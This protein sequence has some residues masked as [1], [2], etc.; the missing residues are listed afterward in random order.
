MIVSYKD[1]EEDR[2]R[3][4]EA[5]AAYYLTKGSFHDETL[6][7]GRRRSDRRGAVMRI[8]IVDDARRGGAPEARDP[9]R[10]RARGVVARRQRGRAGGAVR[11][12][13]AGSGAGE[14]RP[15]V[16]DGLAA[17]RRLVRDARSAVLVT[18]AARPIRRACSRPSATAPSTPSSLHDAAD[19][20]AIAAVL[21]PKIA[22]M[23]RWIGKSGA[24]GRARAAD[25]RGAT[26]H[27]LIAIGASAGGPA[28]LSVVLGGAAADAARG[29]RGRAAS[30]RG[31]HRGRGR[32]AA[33]QHD[34]RRAGGARG[35]PARGRHRAGGRRQRSPDV[36]ERRAA[37]LHRGAAR[38]DLPPL[39]RRVLPQRV[40]AVARLGR[41]R[42]AHRDG[43]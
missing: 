43:A 18:A 5:G 2:R 26:C 3:G 32:V 36:Q 34:A 31:L 27:R 13:R 1:R 24:R 11:R 8:G 40:P 12:Q 9:A 15:A 30:R 38:Q 28:A 39:D 4:L 22:S 35:R 17:T 42:A 33:A 19:V 41:G 23:A 16:V 20:A 29:D 14:R 10:G 37:G 6:R 25:D 21:L 7:A